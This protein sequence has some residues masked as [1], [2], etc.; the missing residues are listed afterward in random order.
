ML[1][2]SACVSYELIEDLLSS[3]VFWLVLS[4]LADVS[5]DR[6]GSVQCFCIQRVTTAWVGY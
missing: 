4:L 5:S 3:V 2:L 6:F 1:H